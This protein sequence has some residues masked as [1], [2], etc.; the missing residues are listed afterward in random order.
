MNPYERL[1]ACGDRELLPS[2]QAMCGDVSAIQNEVLFDI[3]AYAADTEWGR[4]HGFAG[5]RSMDEFRR[6][7]PPTE[8]SDYDAISRRM[9]NGE[10][11]LLFPGR[12]VIFLVTSSSEGPHKLIPESERGSTAKKSTSRLRLAA[13][14]RAFPE[15]AREGD[16][17]PLSNRPGMGRT[18]AGIPFA[19]ASGTT[20]ENAPDTV[21]RRLAFPMEVLRLE[22]QADLDYLIM[23]F[24]LERDVRI[25]VGNN[26]GRLTSL[27]Q[28]ADKRREDLIRDIAE[29][30]LSVDLP[31]DSRLA[32][33]L[34]PAANPDKA[35][36]L[37]SGL[38]ASGR[39]LP[40]NY[41][42][43]L[44]LVSFWLAGSVGR[45]MAELDPWLPAGVSRMD[46]GYGASEAKLNVPLTSGRAAGPLALHAQF[47]E[48]VPVEGGDP[49]LAHELQDGQAYRLLITT[50][51]GLYRY[52]LHDVVRVE[53]FTAGCPNL[54][55]ENKA[56]DVGNLT[57][58]RLTGSMLMRL[59]GPVFTDSG[60]VPRHWCAVPD[61]DR[62]GYDIC[63]E[64]LPGTPDAPADLARR[65]EAALLKGAI[66]Y[67]Y[68]RDQRMLRPLRVLLMRDG[69]QDR[70]YASRTR[71]GVSISQ[72]KLP[73]VHPVQTYPEMVERV[74]GDDPQS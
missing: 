9:Q 59:L 40:C 3:L 14:M 13:L 65:L 45:Y 64:L 6:L 18:P 4:A 55:F 70:L 63:M 31:P 69:W 61:A 49:R 43:K 24:A 39:L 34:C 56:G 28:M 20:L 26:P 32:G 10:E 74:L 53:G 7:Q 67:Q 16:I 19:M 50:Y 51:S 41:W 29:G 46:C 22:A 57:G 62:H 23:R 15:L 72:V 11:N 8:W 58:E 71:P 37:E 68:M 66:G 5:I 30:T 38:V 2:F 42:P 12:P 1:L 35:R 60:V 47:V 25:V 52:D 36:D 27:L 44:N 73:V 54:V 21:M 17:L 33:D 48:F